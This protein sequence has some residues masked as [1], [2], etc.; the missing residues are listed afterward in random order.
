MT[1]EKVLPN[2]YGI[3]ATYG[4]HR[5][6]ER[7]LSM[8]LQQDY[9]GEHSLIIYN[10]S[11]VSQTL[12]LPKMG[13]N[14]HVFLV[15]N[16]IDTKTH[17]KYSNLGAIYNDILDILPIDAEVVSHMDDDDLYEDDYISKGIEGLL[18]SGKTA[19]KPARSWYRHPG[20]TSLMQNTLEPSIF[21]RANHLRK[22]GYS[23][24]TT[25]QH[26][27]WVDPLV[28]Q[29]EIYSDPDGKPTMYYNWNDGEKSG[30]KTSGDPNNPKNFDNYRIWNEDHGDKIISPASLSSYIYLLDSKIYAK[31]Q[32]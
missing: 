5:C 24:E 1:K 2:F 16:H 7:V 30:F 17:I 6:V 4:R 29:E 9:E 32:I 26:L 28:Q 12:D 19:Y 25:A 14:K 15:N 23:K 8:Y 10:N 18:K 13:R 3:T 21:V 20:G 11:E 31:K 22:Y 27:H